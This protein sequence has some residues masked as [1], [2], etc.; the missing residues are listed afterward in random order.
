[1]VYKYFLSLT[2]LEACKLQY[3]T[4]AKQLHPDASTGNEEKFKEMK[5]EYDYIIGGDAR[6]PLMNIINVNIRQNPYTPEQAYQKEKTTTLTPEELNNHKA[7]VYFDSKRRTDIIYDV[8]DDI[9][10]TN[11]TVLNK[12]QSIFTLFDLEVDHFKYIA[13][14]LGK[15]SDVAYSLYKKYVNDKVSI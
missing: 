2:N 4:L 5:N 14:K 10:D 12:Y 6:F 13:W 11:K 3:K 8:L 7:K 1:M 15:K 9:L